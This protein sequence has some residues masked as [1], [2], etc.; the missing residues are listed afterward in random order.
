MSTIIK[1]RKGETMST[2]TLTP[3]PPDV[4]ARAIAAGDAV[5]PLKPE[6][7]L[8]HSQGIG[9]RT[10][11]NPLGLDEALL[12]TGPGWI[13]GERSMCKK[14]MQALGLAVP[15]VMA[16][17]LKVKRFCLRLPW[18]HD[19]RGVQRFDARNYALRKGFTIAADLKAMGACIATIKEYLT[20]QVDVGI[21]LG[22]D[23]FG[24]QSSG[25][26]KDA[27]DELKS[28]GVDFVVG[29]TAGDL[30]IGKDFVEAMYM[31][32]I[33]TMVEPLPWNPAMMPFGSF[34]TAK[35][36]REAKKEPLPTGG[37]ANLLESHRRSRALWRY[38]AAECQPS[39]RVVLTEGVQKPGE[40]EVRDV[41]QAVLDGCGVAIGLNLWPKAGEE[42]EWILEGLGLGKK[43]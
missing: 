16:R 39:E 1:N 21:Y 3:K 8:M 12:N 29:D 30:P 26:I 13:V 40:Q 25:L 41:R 15:A 28:L 20:D 31:R 5:R 6:I 18:G 35:Q 9:G 17:G 23:G 4:V 38:S 36:W 34:C 19:D 2:V 33:W 7:T 32:G 14:L 37:V 22:I 11:E 43:P 42:T 27:A 10:R 24:T